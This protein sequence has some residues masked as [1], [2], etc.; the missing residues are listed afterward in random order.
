MWYSIIIGDNMSREDQLI[1][2]SPQAL[3]ILKGC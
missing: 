2:L 3:D 1:G